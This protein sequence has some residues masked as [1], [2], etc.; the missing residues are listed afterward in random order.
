MMA[1]SGAEWNLAQRRTLVDKVVRGKGVT[2]HLQNSGTQYVSTL[3]IY[4]AKL[5]SLFPLHLHHRS[6]GNYQDAELF[7]TDPEA[8]KYWWDD[9]LQTR[10]ERLLKLVNV[11]VK[12]SLY[13]PG[14]V[15]R[16]PGS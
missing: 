1:K 15:L 6:F 3:L 14:H 9:R 11:K 7:M 8:V 16:V 12:Q 2:I 13:M 10:V 5:I 4:H